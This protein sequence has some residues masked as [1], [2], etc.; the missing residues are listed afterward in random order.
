M[1]KRSHGFESKEGWEKVFERKKG[2]E[3][4]QLCNYVVIAK[5]KGENSRD[6]D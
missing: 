5:P 3:R 6:E 1:K 2:K 4:E